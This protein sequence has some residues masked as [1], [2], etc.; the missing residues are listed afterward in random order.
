MA[1]IELGAAE[2]GL[3]FFEPR[4][5][6]LPG[7]DDR[8][9]KLGQQR[10]GGRLRLTGS[11]VEPLGQPPHMSQLEESE[12]EQAKKDCNHGRRGNGKTEDAGKHQHDEDHGRR[13]GK[14]GREF[15][16][17]DRGRQAFGH[18][19]SGL[20]LRESIGWWSHSLAATRPACRDSVK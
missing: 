12:Q 8:A 11:Q 16:N 6:V 20:L 17:P 1:R 2:A 13:K 9:I 10:K 3:K 18:V 15:Q 7:G 4:A 14:G 19:R 5:P